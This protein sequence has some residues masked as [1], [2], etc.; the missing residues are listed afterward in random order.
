[1]TALVSS[2]LYPVT[3]LGK[4]KAIFTTLFG[5][6]PTTDS[7]YYVG[8]EVSGLQI[9]LI[10]GGHEDGVTGALP[11]VSV[12]NIEQ[13]V[14]DLVTAGAEIVTPVRNVGPGGTVAVVKDTDGSHIGLIQNPQ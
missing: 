14:A 8:Y 2:I 10:P 7:P 12:E 13:A 5:Q 6:E 9:G 4:A 3:D 1:M 11:Y